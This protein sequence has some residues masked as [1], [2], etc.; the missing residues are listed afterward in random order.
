MRLLRRCVFAGG[1]IGATVLLLNACSREVPAPAAD[2]QPPASASLADDGCKL[3]V[4]LYSFR[5][6]LERDLAGTLARIKQL[7]LSCVET[8][9][10]HGRTAEEMRAELDKAGLEVVS[11]H[12]PFASL[13]NPAEVVRI[14][15]TLG[16]RQVG[17]AWVK[18]GQ[19]DVVDEARLTETAERLNGLCD[20]ASAAGLK[21]FY[22]I[23]GYEFHAGDPDAT[24]FDRFMQRL[25]PACVALQIDVYW[26]AFAAQDPVALLQ[27]YADRTLSLHIKDMAPSV[28]PAPLDGS[29]WTGLGDEAFA[30]VGEGTLD[31]RALFAAARAASVRW[32]ILEDETTRPF[33][34]VAASLSYLHQHGF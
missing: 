12:V 3:A 14:A 10:L 11:S 23:H 5:N 21:V 6:E 15:S 20:A 32:Y 26:T 9:S 34:N 24:L 31:W 18:E 30:V 16:A 4:Q 29:N 28:E 8:Y 33:E 22:H 25:D 2:A 27:R 1:L 7:G 19:D 13:T 17:V